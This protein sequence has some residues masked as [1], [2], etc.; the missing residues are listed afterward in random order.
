MENNNYIKKY[1]ENFIENNYLKDEYVFKIKGDFFKFVLYKDKNE[2]V[3]CYDFEGNDIDLLE[4]YINNRKQY[5]EIKQVRSEY[6]KIKNFDINND[7]S[8]L[9]AIQQCDTNLISNIVAL[10]NNKIFED[11]LN[12]NLNFIKELIDNMNKNNINIINENDIKIAKKM[13]SKG[14]D[15]NYLNYLNDLPTITLEELKKIEL[16][17]YDYDMAGTPNEKVFYCK[18][19]N[20]YGSLI[21]LKQSV[22]QAEKTSKGLKI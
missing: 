18:E 13:E 5:E 14:E 7:E 15:L 21:Q 10:K 3:V 8:C 17:E 2:N 1:F 22:E 12:M 4:N 11:T 19:L 6:S 9:L 16:D 20:S